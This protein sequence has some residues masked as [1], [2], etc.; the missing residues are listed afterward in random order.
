MWGLFGDN[1][2]N[3]KNAWGVTTGSKDIRV[4]VIDSGIA[5]HEDLNA[6]V[7]EGHDFF[8]DNTTTSDDEL[9]HG[10]HV[11]GTIGAVADN[12]IGISGV[13]QDITLVPLQVS[14]WENNIND[15]AFHTQAIVNAI[16][17]ACTSYLAQK[18]FQ[19]LIIP[20][21]DLVMIQLLIR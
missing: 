12:G 10:T 19:Y 15:Y 4:G 7:A 14:Y 21:K 6:N 20:V 8:N 9:G 11:A 2:I 17:D 3:A 18:G 16:M 1:G 5:N 13:A